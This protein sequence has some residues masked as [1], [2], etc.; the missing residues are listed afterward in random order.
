LT[1]AGSPYVITGTDSDTDGDSG[2]WTYTLT[3]IALP[4]NTSVLTQT[5]PTTGTVVTTSSGEFTA[6]PITVEHNV[7][8]VTFVTTASNPNLAVSSSGEI[9]TTGSLAVGTYIVSGTDSDPSGDH[10]TWTFT[11]TVTAALVTVTFDA[12]GGTGVMA[13]ESENQPTALSLNLFKRTKYTFVDWNTSANGSGEKYSNGTVYSFSAPTQLF[14]QWRSGKVPTHSI[15]FK[16]NGGSGVEASEVDNTPTAISE[17][18]FKRNGFKFVNWNT[19]A[20]GSGATFESG[21]TYPFKKSVV[22]YA[23]WKKAAVA[24]V[25]EVV[26]VANGG[27]GAMSPEHHHGPA[28][29]ADNHF[30]RKH[31]TFAKWNTAPN[32]SGV[33]YANGAAFSFA[34]STTLYAQWK[35]DKAVVVPPPTGPKRSGV[36]I[37]TFA[38]GTA[39]L[40]SELESQVGDLASTVKTEG[41]TQIT[42][43]GYGDKLTVANE[44]NQS[45]LK[46]SITLGR[47]RAAAV[48]TYLEGRLTALGVKGWTISIDSAS[49]TASGSNN[50]DA[51]TV[52]ASMS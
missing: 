4:V 48:A 52:F 1:A 49:L 34:S 12:N 35:K 39:T 47:T 20:N 30:T 33:S 31:F 10:G 37:G 19:A 29:L 42:L 6:G 40:T 50:S 51:A 24:V 13:P 27:V 2:T 45:F 14:A 23:Q 5:S 8:P 36:P 28:A 43:Y 21:A 41:K 7:G 25:P 9:T 22:L 44:H 26:F 46:A 18:H 38:P 3:V 15:T 16:A 11:L 32:G 17:N